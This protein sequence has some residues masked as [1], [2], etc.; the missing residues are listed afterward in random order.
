[1]SG[2][3]KY[4]CKCGKTFL[5]GWAFSSHRCKFKKN[6]GAHIAKKAKKSH[7]SPSP[8]GEEVQDKK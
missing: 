8:R 3:Y 5:T 7:S 1:M 2:F 6:A 4:K